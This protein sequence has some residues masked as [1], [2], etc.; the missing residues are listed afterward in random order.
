MGARR[1]PG[2]FDTEVAGPF[3]ACLRP[4]QW[5]AQRKGGLQ[6]AGG[7]IKPLPPILAYLSA[8]TSLSL[9]LETR[10]VNSRRL[11]SGGHVYLGLRTDVTHLFLPLLI[12]VA[13]LPPVVSLLNKLINNRTIISVMCPILSKEI[14]MKLVQ[15]TVITQSSLAGK[16]KYIHVKKK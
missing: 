4:V 1:G 8:K 16:A 2:I 12:L 5:G 10:A 15:D 3:A 11:C 13:E 6:A 9:T 7:G 14:Y